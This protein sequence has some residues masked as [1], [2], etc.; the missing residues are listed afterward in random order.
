MSCIVVGGAK[1]EQSVRGAKRDSGR[2]PF[3]F[4]PGSADSKHAAAVVC[5][6]Q[7][8]TLVSLLLRAIVLFSGVV[9]LA[10]QCAQAARGEMLASTPLSRPPLGF[11]GP[12]HPAETGFSPAPARAEQLA[13]TLHH[14]SAPGPPRRIC[15]GQG[16]IGYPGMGQLSGELVETCTDPSKVEDSFW[17]YAKL[18]PQTLWAP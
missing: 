9:E 16:C 3:R 18:V 1:S 8:A 6:F 13:L 15:Q 4:L 17:W 11:G 12:R 10:S 7:N 5:R 2:E 14:A